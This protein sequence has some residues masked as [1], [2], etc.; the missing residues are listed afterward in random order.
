MLTN[1][2]ITSPKNQITP[3]FKKFDNFPICTLSDKFETIP[4]TV[5]TKVSGRINRVIAL[6]IKTTANIISGCI[7]ETDAIFPRSRH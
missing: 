7:N 4:N 6:P 1:I 2:V 5:A 3:D